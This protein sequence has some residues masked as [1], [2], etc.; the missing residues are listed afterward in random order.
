MNVQRRSVGG[1]L[2]LPSGSR[3]IPNSRRR[4]L[5]DGDEDATGADSPVEALASSVFFFSWGAQIAE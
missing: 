1:P 2:P 5:R 4:Q 3:P